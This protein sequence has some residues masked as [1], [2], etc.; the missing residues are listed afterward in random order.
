MKDIDIKIIV[1]EK[2]DY[3]YWKIKMHLHILS[4][5]TSYVKCIEMGPHVPMNHITDINL[6]GSI[7]ADKFVP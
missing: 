2:E 3:F 5:D 6:D 4:L 1:L 7:D